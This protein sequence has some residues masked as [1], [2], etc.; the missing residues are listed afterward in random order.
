MEKSHKQTVGNSELK[1]N[2]DGMLGFFDIR[3]SQHQL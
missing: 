3:N 2:E 1:L